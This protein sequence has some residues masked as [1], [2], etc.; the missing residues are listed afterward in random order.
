MLALR[1][2]VI[3]ACLAGAVCAAGNE[4][5]Q[6]A[7]RLD[8]LAAKAPKALAIEFRM[9]AAEAVAARHPELAKKFVAQCVADLRAGD[10]WVVG[11]GVVQS[12]AQISPE[13]ALAVL[14]HLAPGYTQIVIGALAR[15]GRTDQAI[16]LYL[17]LLHRG[18]MRPA[19]A[20]AILGPLSREDSARAVKFFE[21]VVAAVPDPPDPSDAAWMIN[22]AGSIGRTAPDVAAAAIERVLKAASAPDYG[23]L[24]SPVILGSFAAGEKNITTTKTRDTLLLAAAERLRSIAPD[25]LDK[26]KGALSGWDLSGGLHLRSISYRASTPAAVPGEPRAVENEITRRMGQ[27]RGKATDA[28][29]AQ[30]VMEIARDIRGLPPGQGKI[31]AIRSL[32]S[33][34]TEGALGKEALT[35]VAATMGEAIRDSFPVLI[36]ARR[37]WPYGD[38]WIELA[39]LVRYERVTAPYADPALDAAGALLEVRERVEQ[40]N[41]FTLAGMDGKSYTL[42]GLKGRVVLLN[43]WATWCPPCRKEMPD[44]EKLY[45]ELESKGLTVLAVSDEDRETVAQFLAKTPYTFP[46]LLDP[47]GKAHA[48]FMVEGIPK[49]FIFDREGRLAAQAIDMRT[50]AQFREL[51]KLAGL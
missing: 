12:L 6:A 11:D 41:G 42:A 33:L 2:P 23:E 27:I 35:A 34:S 51:L 36:E 24:A 8:E 25:R 10:G 5:D 29:R 17:D 48:A 31:G 7:Q 21:Q 40:E 15:A 30:L 20:S 16:A 4:V 9:R 47:G 39:K 13:D 37:P 19:G 14:P 43:F 38:T 28:E 18:Q 46:V 1:L 49:S 26:Y 50:E 44:M 3:A 22:S 45:R 32:A